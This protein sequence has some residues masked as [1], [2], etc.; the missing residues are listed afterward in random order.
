LTF[1]KKLPNTPKF[2]HAH[3]MHIPLLN[4]PRLGNLLVTTLFDFLH[5]SPR[6][7]ERIHWSWPLVPARCQAGQEGG[8]MVLICSRPRGMWW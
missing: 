5:S 8:R 4:I 6:H 1:H 7:M 2:Y 3:I